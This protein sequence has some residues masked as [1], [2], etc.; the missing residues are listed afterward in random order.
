M[1]YGPIRALKPGRSAGYCGCHPEELKH[2]PD[3]VLP[4]LVDIFSKVADY[5]FPPHMLQA[6]VASIP[7]QA[8]PA[9]I[10]QLRPITVM[11]SLYWLWA[12]TV[13]R[14]LLREWS[15]TTP[16]GVCG[17]MP[18][19]SA[20]DASLMRSAEPALSHRFVTAIMSSRGHDL[21]LCTSLSRY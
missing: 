13:S 16:S 21:S 14:A 3:E 19:R 12:S 15:K 6:Y 9:G 7:K 11:S 4:D 18:G 8:G 10:G 1:V 20:R 17:S 2:M 5:G